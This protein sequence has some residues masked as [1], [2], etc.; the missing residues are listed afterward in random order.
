MDDAATLK[1][2]GYVGP[3]AARRQGGL[4]FFKNVSRFVQ[5][6]D[7]GHAGET[8]K[9]LDSCSYCCQ[10]VPTAGTEHTYNT[11]TVQLMGLKE[12]TEEDCFS[13]MYFLLVPSLHP[14]CE[15]HNFNFRDRWKIFSRQ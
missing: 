3:A 6:L 9:C 5:V 15:A 11:A 7:K 2:H 8:G 10:A 1:E 14:S 12:A 4:I 13:S